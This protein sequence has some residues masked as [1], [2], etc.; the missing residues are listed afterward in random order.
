MKYN[1]TK[2]NK[3]NYYH[4]Y[5]KKKNEE[6]KNG[7]IVARKISCQ[8]QESYLINRYLKINPFNKKEYF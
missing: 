5:Q 8:K 4:L 1:L 3:N 6:I 7:N 2:I